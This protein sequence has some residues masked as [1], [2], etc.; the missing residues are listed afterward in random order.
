MG[1]RNWKQVL[2]EGATGRRGAESRR[3]GDSEDPVTVSCHLSLPR[4]TLRSTLNPLATVAAVRTSAASPPSPQHHPRSTTSEQV[5]SQAGPS[6]PPNCPC[7]ASSTVWA[8]QNCLW[9]NRA[10]VPHAA[11]LGSMR[12]FRDPARA[13]LFSPARCSLH[14]V[15]QPLSS[16]SPSHSPFTL[17]FSTQASHV[18]FFVLFPYGL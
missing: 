6:A 2:G 4:V 9:K 11:V 1:T 8:S 15:V 16:P 18:S 12:Q 5:T 7:S 3:E 17:A 14:T 13:L 10:H